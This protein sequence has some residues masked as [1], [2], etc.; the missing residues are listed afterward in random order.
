MQRQYVPSS[1][2]FS[3]QDRGWAWRQPRQFGT[4][5]VPTRR[6]QTPY[7]VRTTSRTTYTSRPRLAQIPRSSPPLSDPESQSSGDEDIQEVQ[8]LPPRRQYRVLNTESSSQTHLEPRLPRRLSVTLEGLHLVLQ[9]SEDYMVDDE[10]RGDVVSF[11]ET[12]LEDLIEGDGPPSP[13]SH[14]AGDSSSPRKSSK[15]ATGEPTFE[16]VES[17]SR[18]K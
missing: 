6:P 18:Q 16:Q 4:R 5:T 9:W 12:C 11:L 10:C 3:T 14:H 15:T 2:R 1:A 13:P 17:S 8:P 7:P